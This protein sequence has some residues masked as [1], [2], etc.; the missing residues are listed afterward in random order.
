MIGMK[1]LLN[2]VCTEAIEGTWRGGDG[3][4]DLI[5]ERPT[6]NLPPIRYNLELIKSS[7]GK[8]YWVE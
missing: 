5:S 8:L 4:P 1:S 6:S 7:Y 2:M 3:A